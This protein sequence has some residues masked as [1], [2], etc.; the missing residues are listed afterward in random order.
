MPVELDKPLGASVTLLVATRLVDGMLS[1]FGLLA[2]A[3]I[4]LA[5]G[6]NAHAKDVQRPLMSA[7]ERARLLAACPA[8]E[9]YARFAQ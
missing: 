1:S 7:Q 5:T 3:S 6:Q 2:F 8:Y 9:H 4:C